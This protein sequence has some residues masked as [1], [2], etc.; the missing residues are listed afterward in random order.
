MRWKFKRFEE[1]MK[2]KYAESIA[3]GQSQQF[4]NEDR[5]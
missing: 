3:P 2:K 1:C 5:I 4:I